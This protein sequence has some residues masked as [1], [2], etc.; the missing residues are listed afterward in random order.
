MSFLA[1]PLDSVDYMIKF[2]IFFQTT[3]RAYMIHCYKKSVQRGPQPC[4]VC[5]PVEDG[6][7][8]RKV[9]AISITID[10]LTGVQQMLTVDSLSDPLSGGKSTWLIRA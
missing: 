9:T 7:G 3:D 4:W 2:Q 1:D 8:D 5:N 10:R 6:E